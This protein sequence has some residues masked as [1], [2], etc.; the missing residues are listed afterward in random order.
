MEKIQKKIGLEGFTKV[1]KVVKIQSVL[2]HIAKGFDT[3]VKKENIT[4]LSTLF[5][6]TIAYEIIKFIVLF[7]AFC[8]DKCDGIGLLS[9]LA[10]ATVVIVFAA[11]SI[12]F[13]GTFAFVLGIIFASMCGLAMINN[14][15]IAIRLYTVGNAFFSIYNLVMMILF[16]AALA[17]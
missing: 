10:I 14:F 6:V 5:T 3:T 12:S 13:G 16:I 1:E 9:E 2:I 15:I 7:I 4:M 11:L 17:L 8:N